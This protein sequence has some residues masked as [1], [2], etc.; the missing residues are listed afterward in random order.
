VRSL[1]ILKDGRNLCTVVFLQNFSKVTQGDGAAKEPVFYKPG[2]IMYDSNFS[3]SLLVLKMKV[4]PNLI[5]L[6]YNA[7]AMIWLNTACLKNSR[8]S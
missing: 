8:K 7:D 3:C 1:F 6:I 2:N 4:R 5:L